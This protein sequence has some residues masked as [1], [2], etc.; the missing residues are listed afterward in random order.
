MRLRMNAVR[1]AARCG[2]GTARRRNA[3]A[4]YLRGA[5]HGFFRC[6]ARALCRLHSIVS[7]SQL[8]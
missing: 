3:A 4:A 5:K 8:D 1:A 2:G 6:A 7:E